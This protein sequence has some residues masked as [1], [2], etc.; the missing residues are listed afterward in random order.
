MP[1][2]TP[3]GKRP[4]AGGSERGQGEVRAAHLVGVP[5]ADG[6][7]EGHFP[8]QQVVHPAEGELQVPHLVLVQV[9]VDLLCMRQTETPRL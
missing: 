1:E 8:H 9:P 7:V 3:S 5:Q 4:V 2:Q 6:A